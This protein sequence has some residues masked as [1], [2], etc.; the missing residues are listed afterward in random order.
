VEAVLLNLVQRIREEF[1]EAPGLHF[2]VSEASRFWGL[3]EPTAERVLAQLLA[4]GFLAR[5]DDERFSKYEV[6]STKFEAQPSDSR[7][8]TSDFKL[9]TSD[10]HRRARRSHLRRG[11]ESRAGAR[12]PDPADPPRRRC[13]AT[14]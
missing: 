14:G 5:G 4:T 7:L 10:F 1:E 9:Q 12:S 13:T 11:T 8:Q 6:R 2:T 3:D